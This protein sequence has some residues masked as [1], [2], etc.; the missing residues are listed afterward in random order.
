MLA[1]RLLDRRDDQGRN[2]WE[3]TEDYLYPLGINTVITVP[4]GYITNFGTIPRWCYCLITPAEMREAAVVHDFLCNENFTLDQAPIHPGIPRR[5]ADA[6]LFDHMR[7]IGIGYFRAYA[8][9]LAVRGWAMS[10]G[11]LK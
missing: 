5:V 2:L 4:A 9:Y 10:T 1:V 8:V 3:L 7:R 11:Q 6:I